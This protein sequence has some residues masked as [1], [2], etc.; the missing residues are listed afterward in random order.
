MERPWDYAQGLEAIGACDFRS[1]LHEIH[2]P[3]LVIAGGADSATTPAEAAF[4]ASAIGNPPGTL[5]VIEDAAH[6]A[7]V[8]QAEEFN[9]A[10]IDHLSRT[11]VQAPP[12]RGRSSDS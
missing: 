3:T 9:Q 11:T 5:H 1:R 12:V 2:A 7:N 10:L 4:L 6:L 8:E